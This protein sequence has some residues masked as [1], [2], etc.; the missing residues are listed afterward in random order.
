M[1]SSQ[2]ALQTGLL[3]AM[4]QVEHVVHPT[5][6]SI[7]LAWQMPDAIWL[8]PA[9]QATLARYCALHRL[10]PPA[11]F[12][13]QPAVATLLV[14]PWMRFENVL[15]YLG[16]SLAGG[17]IRQVVMRHEIQSLR[18][19]LG[20]HA[21]EFACSEAQLIAD[22]DYRTGYDLSDETYPMVLKVVGA[23]AVREAVQKISTEA[24]ERLRHK[25]NVDLLQKMAEYEG[26]IP[27][28]SL[29]V[30]RKLLRELE[31]KWHS[32]FAQMH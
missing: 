18:K 4:C 14:L 28:Y 8:A 1:P 24:W 12:G 22:G 2:I 16:L 30:I 27:S 23:I 19:H 6:R 29:A 11:E 32:L 31:P 15:F 25:I 17:E 9:A 26:S 5:Q 20:D 7:I 13:N 10:L 3:T 21:Y